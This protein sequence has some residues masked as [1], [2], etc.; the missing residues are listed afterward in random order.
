[1]RGRMTEHSPIREDAY[2]AV[3]GDD[4]DLEALDEAQRVPHSVPWAFLHISVC[5]DP[6]QVKASIEVKV[7]AWVP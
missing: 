2:D 3:A 1:M 4:D 6:P 5:G 7:S